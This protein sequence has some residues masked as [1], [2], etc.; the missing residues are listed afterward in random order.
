M[1]RH[2]AFLIGVADE[3][4]GGA[5]G[6]DGGGVGGVAGGVERD[7]EEA[8]VFADGGAQG[9][10]VFA[11]PGGEDQGIETAEAG[12]QGA[13]FAADAPLM[14]GIARGEYVYFVHSY[15]A[16]VGPWTVATSDYGGEFSA[17]VQQRN[18]NGAQFHPE[19]SGPVGA[20]LLAGF[21]ELA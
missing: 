1:E 21:L 18:F 17:A 15:R 2:H 13:D 20:R 4:R 9:G 10:G 3:D 16:P 8:E 12:G 5:V 6:G 7:A 19:R 11:D 14:T